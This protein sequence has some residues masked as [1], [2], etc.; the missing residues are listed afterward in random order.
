M[1][2]AVPSGDTLV[3]LEV[4]VCLRELFLF[5]APHT[6]IIMVIGNI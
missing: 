2:L 5:W 1:F 3:A 6:I 4:S